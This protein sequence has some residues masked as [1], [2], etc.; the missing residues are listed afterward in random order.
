MYPNIE[1]Y[2]VTFITLRILF[3]TTTKKKK[4]GKDEL[5]EYS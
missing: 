2:A 5:L 1:D 4:N 3:F